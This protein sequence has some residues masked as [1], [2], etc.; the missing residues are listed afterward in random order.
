MSE[1]TETEGR[2]DYRDQSTIPEEFRGSYRPTFR[3]IQ[4]QEVKGSSK[5][6]IVDTNLHVQD[7]YAIILSYFNT[8]N[9]SQFI[10]GTRKQFV[11]RSAG[12]VIGM[13][14]LKF[15][16]A[17]MFTGIWSFVSLLGISAIVGI[18]ASVAVETMLTVYQ[19]SVRNDAIRGITLQAIFF[20]VILLVVGAFV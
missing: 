5:L 16:F 2:L 17:E 4:K 20:I 15:F 10:L 8:S 11:G 6:M 3:P 12:L 1:K 18:V 13:F 14:F 9:K 19:R 7:P